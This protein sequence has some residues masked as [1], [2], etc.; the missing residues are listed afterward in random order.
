MDIDERLE[1]LAQ[2]TVRKALTVVTRLDLNEVRKFF[3]TTPHRAGLS[4]TVG[5]KLVRKYSV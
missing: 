2:L 1:R 3:T 4:K 5:G